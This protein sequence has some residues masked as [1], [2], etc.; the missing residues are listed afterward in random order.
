[1][2]LLRYPNVLTL[3]FT[4]KLYPGLFLSPLFGQVF[5][6]LRSL[7]L[8]CRW[9]GNVEFVETGTLI[10]IPEIDSF[11]GDTPQTTEQNRFL[12]GGHTTDH[13]TE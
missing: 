12:P 11:R 2:A 10:I 8:F 4:L 3:F 1:M 13:G 6:F 7:F 5:R 9:V